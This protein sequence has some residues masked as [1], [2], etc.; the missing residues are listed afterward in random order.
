MVSAWWLLLTFVGGGLAGTMLMAVL[1]MS[2]HQ[3]KR[4]SSRLPN[5]NSMPW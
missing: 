2:A 3:P 4:S 1:Q 5:F